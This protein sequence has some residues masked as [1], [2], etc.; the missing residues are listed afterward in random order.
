MRRPSA[1][2]WALVKFFKETLADMSLSAMSINSFKSM[3]DLS[4]QVALV[5][6]GY[7]AI[8][9]AISWGLA[10]QGVTV[11]FSGSA[12][13]RGTRLSN[14]LK[15]PGNEVHTFAFDLLRSDDVS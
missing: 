9:E 6:G 8:G 10:M 12:T 3:F 11:A 14:Q 2:T 13:K 15:K 7:G 5:A 1:V 4:G